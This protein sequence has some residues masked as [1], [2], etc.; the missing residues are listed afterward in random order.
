M[1]LSPPRAGRPRA[2]AST[3]SRPRSL[4]GQ[5]MLPPRLPLEERERRLPLERFWLLLRLL[6]PERRLA[7]LLRPP[8]LDRD[9][10]YWLA[11]IYSC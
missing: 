2:L 6:A 8:L 4:P 5:R 1:S 7:A 11:M 10:V 9:L 3:G